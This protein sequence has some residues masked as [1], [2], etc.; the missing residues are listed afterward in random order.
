MNLEQTTALLPEEW[1]IPAQPLNGF[2][3]DLGT[4]KLA[5]IE[6]NYYANSARFDSP[7]K[8]VIMLH[9]TAAPEATLA[10]PGA[11]VVFN[12]LVVPDEWA[13][14]DPITGCNQTSNTFKHL[15]VRLAVKRLQ[16]LFGPHIICAQ[17]QSF[18]PI[19]ARLGNIAG[20][21]R[22]D[23]PAKITRAIPRNR[24][25]LSIFR[26][27]VEN[28]LYRVA[29]TL[30]NK[31]TVILPDG[32]ILT[33]NPFEYTILSPLDRVMLLADELDDLREVKAKYEKLCNRLKTRATSKKVTQ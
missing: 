24:P 10:C 30:R 26:P 14:L 29:W 7:V 28:Y 23:N 15:V 17:F 20:F 12:D 2:N 8:P 11:T 18:K 5:A 1:R 21:T 19:V 3:I 6:S 31:A 27:G 25:K 4:S 22:F 33:R 16:A 32:R 9:W 13:N